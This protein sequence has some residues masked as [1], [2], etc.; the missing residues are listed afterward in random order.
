MGYKRTFFIIYGSSRVRAFNERQLYITFHDSKRVKEQRF[1]VIKT[2]R[3]N[4]AMDA[5]LVGSSSFI[6]GMLLF[7]FASRLLSYYER[8]FIVRY[9]YYEN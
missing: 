2:P 4:K 3:N 7:R 6:P 5:L 8:A 9:A 1:C